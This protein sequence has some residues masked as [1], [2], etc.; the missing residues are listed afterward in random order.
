[1][2]IKAFEIMLNNNCLP[3]NVK[4]LI[5]GEEEIGSKN[6]IDF[7]DNDDNIKI[8]NSDAVLVS[9]TSILSLNN[10]SISIGLRGILALELEVINAKLDLHSGSYGGFIYNPI[11][12][13]CSIISFFKNNLN[14]ISIPNFYKDV[15][16]VSKFDKYYI[17]KL[18]YKNEFKNKI[19]KLDGELH[20]NNYEKLCIRPSLDI[21]GI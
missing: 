17:S 5:E 14:A 11:N 20:Y 9:D 21:N 16:D 10:P 2:H 3:C 18:P 8:L 19:L 4:F 15:L 6:I 7:L 13:I 12:E 1:M